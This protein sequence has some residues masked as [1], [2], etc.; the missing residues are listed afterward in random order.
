[1]LKK[2]LVSLL[3]SAMIASMCTSVMASDVP[4]ENIGDGTA[5]SENSSMDS[6]TSE[7]ADT[8][9]ADVAQEDDK[10][11]ESNTQPEDANT[12]A[13]TPSGTES[14]HPDTEATEQTASE[15]T[16]TPTAEAPVYDK[17]NS[18]SVEATAIGL[19][20]DATVVDL[21]ADAVNVKASNAR[22]TGPAIQMSKGKSGF[23]INN[24]YGSIAGSL[25]SANTMDY[26]TFSSTTDFFSIS[27]IKSTNANYTM[28]LGVVDWASGS[29]YPTDYVTKANQQF[30]ANIGPGDYAWVIQSSNGTYGANYSLEY[31]MSL[32]A[33]D[34]PIY[35]SS[36]LQTLYSI[37]GQKL[38]LNNQVQNI[39]YAYDRDVEYPDISFWNKLHIYMRNA[40]V[41]VAHVGGAKYYSGSNLHSFPNAIVLSIQ[42]GGNFYHSFWQ[43][44]P[45][46]HYVDEDMYEIKTPRSITD[47]DMNRGGHYLIYNMDT[48]KV[49]E[50]A[51]GLIQ[52]WSSLGDRSGFELY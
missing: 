17:A 15:S 24:K 22:S 47:A 2:L 1:M 19:D 30:M 43:N 48:R 10:L 46:Y 4:T 7:Q 9:N 35:A 52:P 42:P 26:Y 3:A 40:N 21:S 51:S 27:Q 25:T 5:V 14:G 36:D 41:K 29:I 33:T 11:E 28:M 13:S 49:E 37:G 20:G 38:K 32:P 34:T 50:F 18:E 45:H 6:E 8:S 16:D 44:P 39:D 31:N 23:A 12:D